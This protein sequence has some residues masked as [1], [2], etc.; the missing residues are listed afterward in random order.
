MKR[1]LFDIARELT[2]TGAV[3]EGR[4]HRD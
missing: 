1:K 4:R 2:D 3:L